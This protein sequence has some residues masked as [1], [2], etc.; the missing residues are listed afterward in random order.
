MDDQ[1]HNATAAALV[2][3][4]TAVSMALM[5]NDISNIKD[6]IKDI[7]ISMKEIGTRFVTTTEFAEHIKADEDHETRIRALEDIVPDFKTVR[8][9]V[10]GCVTVILLA[11]ISALVYLVV[12]R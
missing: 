3:K 8:K 10:F 9:L 4:D 7:K 11:V 12:N 1:N 6:D 2:A 5:G